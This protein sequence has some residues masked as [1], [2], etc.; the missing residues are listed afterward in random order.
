MNIDI[1]ERALK[2]VLELDIEQKGTRILFTEYKAELESRHLSFDELMDVAAYSMVNAELDADRDTS[3][4]GILNTIIDNYESR[5]ATLATLPWD[6]IMADLENRIEQMN[7][8]SK[9]QIMRALAIGI[10]VQ[11][12]LLDKTDNKKARTT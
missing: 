3:T 2:P 1:F 7:P 9:Q 10:E 11:K 4:I 12:K 8:T 6:E 5:E